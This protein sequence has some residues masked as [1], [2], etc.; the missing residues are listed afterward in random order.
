MS[1]IEHRGSAIDHRVDAIAK[2]TGTARYAGEIPLP[3]KAYGYVLQSTIARG[4]ITS[5]DT[6]QAL[7]SP[8]VL[9]VITHQNAG[10]LQDVG[11]GELNL[12]QDNA[13]HYRGEVVGLVVAET[14]EQA[15]AA[16]ELVHFG[17][18]ET[19]HDVVLRTDHPDVYTPEKV[20]PNFPSETSAGDVDAAFAA[21]AFTVDQTYRTPGE[22]N[23]PME[24]HTATA[25]WDGGR[26]TVYDSSQG[27]STVREQLT[28]LF[29]LGP[30]AVRVVSEHVG[31]GFGSKG[32]TRP[33]AVLAA[34][35][36]RAVGRPVC[37]ALTR[38]QMFALVGYR[39]PTVQRLRLGADREGRLVALDHLAYSQTSH[40]V[41]FAEQTATISRSL[42]ATPN[43]RTRHRLLRLDV[44]TPRWMRAP[45]ET[46][47]SFGIESAMDELAEA[48][49][50]DPVELRI[51]ND[52][53]TEPD[54]GLPFS[55]RNLVACL[56]EGA[57]RIGWAERDPR[58]ASRRDGRWLVGLGVAAST[59][60]A[61]SSPS[62]A[63]VRIEADGTALVRIAAADIGTGS[64]T[65]LTQIAAE[66]LQFPVDRVR[67]EIADSDF[68]H[69]P[70]AGGSM[71]TASW[72]WAVAKA[73]REIRPLL[74]NG[75]PPGNE[76][77]A[78]GGG[79]GSDGLTV[80]VDTKDDIDAQPKLARHG[81]G[82]QFAEVRVDPT[83]GE[84]RVSRMVGVF[85]NGRIVNPTTARS[86]YIGGMT[87]GI[88][89]ALLEE[90]VM[91]REFGDYLNHDLA[92][93]HMPVN[94]DVPEI[95]VSWLDEQDDRLNLLGVK[96]IGEIGIVGAAAA[97]ANAVWHATG[98]RQREL[99][100]R[101]D[102]VLQR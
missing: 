99:P 52:T 72:G 56:R 46:P 20:N 23:S 15:R 31:G 77:V 12:L 27:V 9:A 100:I 82:A 36:A 39:T 34:L 45:G 64:R 33:H 74:K 51:R 5:I 97:I 86:Q 63:T 47:G 68:G 44:P 65:A 88:G 54:S 61:R 80:R 50:I 58:P 66:E 37:V 69:A 28:N 48:A 6:E 55:S 19:E 49:G 93:Y 8:G 32:T 7:A 98:V 43:L 3:G 79:V 4:H 91:D 96:G 38:Q 11:D 35:A 2:V 76:G 73:C 14:I 17:Y 13:V 95:D 18:E 10:R 75:G 30:D 40:L 94:A 89:M 53:D 25:H 78:A 59:Y 22:H 26:L 62:T 83:T 102:R 42:H 85:A 21:A 29:A 57:R 24:P 71:G 87:M 16:G 92:Q 81:F 90:G 70:V 84:V 60:P 101:P 67:L 41:E 1:A